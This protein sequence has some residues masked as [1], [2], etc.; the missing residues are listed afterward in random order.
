MLV[1]YVE[2]VTDNYFLLIFWYG[3]ELLVVVDVWRGL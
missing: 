1:Q 3:I 2:D